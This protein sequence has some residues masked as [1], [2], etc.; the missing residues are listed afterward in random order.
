MYAANEARHPVTISGVLS[1]LLLSLL[2]VMTSSVGD[3]F[4]PTITSDDG[5]LHLTFYGKQLNIPWEDVMEERP[6]FNLGLFSKVRVIRARSITPF[7]R[8]YGLIYSFTFY[9]CI[10]Y[11]IHI[12]NSRELA[13][14][15]QARGRID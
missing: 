1:F 12:S 13:E 6:L 5:G 3:N 9:P 7:H 11:S 8:L 4:Y 15:I 10:I 2:F 14:R